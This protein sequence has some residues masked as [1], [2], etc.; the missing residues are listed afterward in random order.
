LRNFFC[1]VSLALNSP[2]TALANA[3][4]ERLE[5][6]ADET[7]RREPAQ[8]LERLKA[9]SERIAALEKELPRPVDPQ[10][11]HYLARCS[12][13]KALEALETKI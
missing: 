10:L 9:I 8:H 2:E 1:F 3:L 6:I 12:Y 11:A 13:D 4:R 5:I 7:S